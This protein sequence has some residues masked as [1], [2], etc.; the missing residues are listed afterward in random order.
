MKVLLVAPQPYY[1]ERGTPIAVRQLARTLAKQDHELHILAYPLGD[2][3]DDPNQIIHRCA[4]IPFI[5][6]VPIGFSIRKLGYDVLLTFSM[7]WLHFRHRFDVIHAIE[8]SIYPALLIKIFSN[9][10]VVYDMDSSLAE[11][12]GTG[13]RSRRSIRKLLDRCEAWAIRKSDQVAAVCDDLVDIAVKYKPGSAV[14]ALY[15]IPNKSAADSVNDSDIEVLATFVPDGSTL[16][17]YVGNLE[18]YQGIDLLLESIRQIGNESTLYTIIIGGT[19]QHISHYQKLS[20]SFGIEQ[21][22]RFLGPRPLDHLDQLLRQA[23][24]LFSPRI[25]GGNTPMK[26][27]SYMASNRPI[28]ATRLSTH[29]QVLDDQSAVLTDAIPVAYAEGTKKLADSVALR[30]EIAGRAMQLVQERY[31][32]D[33]YEKT[34]RS[35]YECLQ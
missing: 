18:P 14:H 28:V 11:Q 15:D 33:N 35:L 32:I 29:T 13:S 16:G 5:T 24:I 26:L 3:P 21:R 4:R 10:R 7:F 17:L 20:E 2:T 12:L 34:V 9:V 6:H 8:E 1:V 30:N 25:T 22:I 31:S 23:D 19:E 27:Y